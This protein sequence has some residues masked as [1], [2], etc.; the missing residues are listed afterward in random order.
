M[1]D[2]LPQIRHTVETSM[3]E[4]NRDWPLFR[5]GDEEDCNQSLFLDQF[6][7]ASQESL[8]VA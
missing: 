8:L 7:E 2:L 6:Q 1:E 4:L 3:L 5:F